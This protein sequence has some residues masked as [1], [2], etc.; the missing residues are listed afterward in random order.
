VPGPT[1][2]VTS[3]VIENIGFEVFRHPPY[4]LDLAP[5]ELW[6]FVALKK[7]LKGFHFTCNEVQCTTGK[8]F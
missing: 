8:W 6:L 5:S 3:A 7:H 2:A 4:S 1:S